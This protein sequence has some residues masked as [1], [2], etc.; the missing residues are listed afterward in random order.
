VKEKPEYDDEYE[1]D[2]ERNLPPDQS[3]VL[4]KS[5]TTRS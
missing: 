2:E 1:Y 5:K 4:R 3:G